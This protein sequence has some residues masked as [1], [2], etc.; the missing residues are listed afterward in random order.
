M[1]SDEMRV[2]VEKLFS[3]RFSSFN[4]EKEGNDYNIFYVFFPKR[5]FEF[6]VTCREDSKYAISFISILT[7][8]VK[9]SNWYESLDAAFTDISEKIMEE[10]E[11]VYY[12]CNALKEN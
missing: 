6:I 7:K 1:T 3:K 10:F 11:D 5:S 9:R 12:V 4:I 2:E 8:Q